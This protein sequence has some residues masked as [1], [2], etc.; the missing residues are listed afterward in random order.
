MTIPAMGANNSRYATRTTG[1]AAICPWRSVSA[2]QTGWLLGAILRGGTAGTTQG[3]AGMLL[4]LVR[5]LR[6]RCPQAQLIL[7][8]DCG[9]GTAAVLSLCGRLKLDFLLGLTRNARLQQLST[10]TQ[11]DA[12]LKYRWAGEGCREFGE[13][14]YQAGSWPTAARVLVKAEITQGELNPRYVVTSLTGEPEELYQTYCAR[15]DRENRWQEF[16][17]DLAAGRTSCT[18]FLANQA[19]L[20]WHVAAALLCLAV[21]LAASGTQWQAAQVG[22]LRTRLFKI[23]ARV[24]QSTRRIWW[25]LPTSCPLQADWVAIALRLC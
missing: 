18:T 22:A 2:A 15:G 6:A 23:G 25:H 19:R 20:L 9:F 16:K 5:R 8:G 10:P 1:R 24:V 21:R 3:L 13:F 4:G 17:L 7:R 14:S 12:A 11:M